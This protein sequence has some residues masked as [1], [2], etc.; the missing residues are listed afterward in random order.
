MGEFVIPE[1]LGGP[2][3]LMIGRVLWN[4]FFNNRDWPTAS[5][6]AILFCLLMVCLLLARLGDLQ[7][8]Q[9][10]YFSTRADD[11]RMRVVAMPPVRGLIYDRNGTLL[12]QNRPSFDLEV[13]RDQ[14]ENLDMLLATLAPVMN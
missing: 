1:L 8:L 11:N 10:E 4:E 12:A 5:A 2:D 9:H 7:L 3:T 13:T 6:V 14:V